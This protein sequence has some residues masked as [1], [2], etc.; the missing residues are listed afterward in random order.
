MTKATNITWHDAAIT[1]ED[2]R[3]QNGHG[4]V[5]LWF[6]GLSGSGKSTIANA[7]SHELFRQ[8]IN[9]YVLD[10]D[11]VRHGLNKDLGFSEADRNENIRRIGEVAKLFVDSGKIVT[12]AFISPFRSDRE[13]VRALFEEGEFIEVFIDCPLEECERRDPKQLYAKARRGEIKDFTG[14]DSPYES[15]ESPEITVRSDQYTVEEAVGQILT[16]LR[17]KII[18]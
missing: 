16:H 8:G 7:V 4:S 6:T 9:E 3:A 11:N 13:T 5:V 12:T 14:I 10:G 2:R 18:L 17:E 1:K 15:P